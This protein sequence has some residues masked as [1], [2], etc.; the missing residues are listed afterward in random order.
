MLL[1]YVYEVRIPFLHLGISENSHFEALGREICFLQDIKSR[2]LAKFIP[3]GGLGMTGSGSMQAPSTG[4]A[5][6][7]Y[8]RFGVVPQAMPEMMIFWMLDVPST[9]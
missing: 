7:P 5:V 6:A 1:P 8:S 4:S 9:T 3:G 2:F